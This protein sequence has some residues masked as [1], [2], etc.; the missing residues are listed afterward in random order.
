MAK[1]KHTKNELKAQR[2]ALRRFQRYLPMLQLKKQQLQRE[3]RRVEAALRQCTA[4]ED[5]LLA[6]LRPW[7]KLLAADPS[8]RPGDHVRVAAADLDTANIA[9]VN[10]PVL[11][12][13]RFEPVAID[14][15]ATP[16]WLEEA[17]RPRRKLTRL[18][19]KQR[20]GRQQASASNSAPRQCAPCPEGDDPRTPGGICVTG[21]PVSCADCCVAGARLPGSGC[22]AVMQVRH[23]ID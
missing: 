14:Y 7:V 20:P 19:L 13:V 1:I 8:A 5:S 9:G 3:V 23:V 4:A 6:R 21:L 15:L 10:V 16:A 22:L 2:D 18:R 11:A 12:D 17:V